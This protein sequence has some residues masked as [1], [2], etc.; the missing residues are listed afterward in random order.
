MRPLSWLL[1]LMLVCTGIPIPADA[2]RKPKLNKTSVKLRVGKTVKLKVKNNKKKVK[3]SSANKKIAT[4]NKKGLVKA[5]KKG[6]TRIIAKIKKKKYICKVTVLANKTDDPDDFSEDSGSDGNDDTGSGNGTQ[7]TQAPSDGT[8]KPGESPGKT[9]SAQ[10]TSA[11]GNTSGPTPTPGEPTP[12]H[13][14]T[15]EPTTAPWVTNTPVV[16]PTQ[17]PVKTSTPTKTP[18][19]TK[20]PTKAPTP[21]KTPTP[22][23]APT[24]A[25]TPTIKP[26][27]TKTPTPTIKPTPT[28]TPSQGGDIP[29]GATVFTINGKKLAIGMTEAAA[30]TVLSQLGTIREGKSPQ[31]FQT[32]A[33]NTSNYSE[34]LLLYLQAGKDSKDSKVVGICGI[35]KSMSYG[36]VSAGQ[37]G[38]NLS[39][40]TNN[41][42][43][44]TEKKLVAAKEKKISGNEQAYAFYDA[45]GDNTVYCIQVFDP[46][47]ACVKMVSQNNNNMIYMTSDNT[48]D[49][50]AITTS[51]VTEVGHMLNAFRA[52]R[53]QAAFT[54][55]SGLAG[56]AQAYCNQADG[57][58]LQGRGDPELINAILAAGTDPGVYGEA[59][60]YDAADAISFANSL[61][62]LDD[63]Y[64]VLVNNKEI[65]GATP[66]WGNAGV[67]MACNGK[68]TYVT[69]DYVDAP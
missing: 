30:K 14:G 3:W 44:K 42:Q 43:Y 47:N 9:P 11:P 39:G 24:K 46:T 6:K 7:V 13:W 1:V 48:Y 69:V 33:C 22:T 55:H 10:K 2:A 26:T 50:S 53:N 4:V 63:F 60:Y 59:C 29:S 28:A 62:E 21:T 34:Y 12:I 58:K 25:P 17:A 15:P 16:N 35:G 19:P 65:D 56:C 68:H 66:V 64:K 51:I 18:T 37:N 23:K 20:A 61:I 5:R 54:F 45:L 57:S 40:W 36:D 27:P 8:A 31:G 52:Y 41:N 32:L 38:N 67:G 49:D